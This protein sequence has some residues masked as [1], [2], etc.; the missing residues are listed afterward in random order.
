MMGLSLVRSS[1]QELHSYPCRHAVSL[2]LIVKLQPGGF[3]FQ[4]KGLSNAAD[5]IIT[6]PASE[7]LERIVGGTYQSPKLK[8]L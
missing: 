4:S 8:F 5:Y 7:S 6:P 3:I 1:W 2:V